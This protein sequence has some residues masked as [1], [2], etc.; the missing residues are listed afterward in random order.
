MEGKSFYLVFAYPT[1]SGALHVGHIRSY[2]LPDIIAKYHLSKHENIFFPV[3]F[4][5]TGSD[6]VKIFNSIK[7]DPDKAES[8]G[9]SRDSVDKINEPAGVVKVLASSYIDL[10]KKAGFD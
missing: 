10:F 8:Y 4:H 9:I 6:A 3:G 1:T 5:A 7:A 2:T